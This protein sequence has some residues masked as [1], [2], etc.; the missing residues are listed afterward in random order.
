[1]THLTKLIRYS[2]EKLDKLKQVEKVTVQQKSAIDGRDFAALNSL[3]E[4]KQKVIDYI[5]WCDNAFQDELNRVKERLGV[6]SFKDIGEMDGQ[7]E[8]KALAEIIAMIIETIERIQA[9]EKDNHKKLL[10]SMD[11]IK[12][13]LKKV[14]NGQKSIAVYDSGIGMASGSFLDKKK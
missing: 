3:V 12:E 8:K 4:E 1:M 2:E 14:K 11:Q 5:D 9:L 13:K 7:G 6:K 10:E